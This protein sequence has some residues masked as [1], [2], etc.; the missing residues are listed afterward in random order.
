MRSRF[1]LVGFGFIMFAV[2]ACSSPQDPSLIFPPSH[3]GE[4]DQIWPRQSNAP[5]PEPDATSTVDAPTTPEDSIESFSSSEEVPLAVTNFC[6]CLGPRNQAQVKVKLAV[7]NSSNQ[8]VS[9]APNDFRMVVSHGFASA[10]TPAGSAEPPL[11]IGGF[12]FLSANPDGAYESFDGAL[13]FATHWA[14]TVLDARA[15]YFE[16]EAKRGDLVFYVPLGSDQSI[17]VVGIA[18]MGA[19]GQTV[20]GFAK[21]ESWLG[22]AN[23]N[24]F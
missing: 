5:A 23:A 21:Y 4:S 15:K 9:I 8:S 24:D 18:L 14:P 12:T 11:T 2:V 3:L 13:T 10:W 22:F 7:D 17:T 20:L 1:C 16:P 19:D 6:L